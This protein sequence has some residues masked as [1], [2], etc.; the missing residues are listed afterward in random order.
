MTAESEL[1]KGKENK[2]IFHVRDVAKCGVLVKATK[3]IVGSHKTTTIP[4]TQSAHPKKYNLSQHDGRRNKH[5]A[6]CVPVCTTFQ[7]IGRIANI[8]LERAQKADHKKTNLLK[9]VSGSRSVVDGCGVDKV[10]LLIS[11]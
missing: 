5:P 6:C 8:S 11:S 1:V 7:I 4:N 2:K 10:V 9:L 3:Q